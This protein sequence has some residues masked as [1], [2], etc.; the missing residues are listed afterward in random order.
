MAAI[1]EGLVVAI[2]E[3]LFDLPALLLDFLLSR[4]REP[5]HRTL[6]DHLRDASD[7]PH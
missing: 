7:R 4:R 6:G 1:L 3:A 5:D 2:I